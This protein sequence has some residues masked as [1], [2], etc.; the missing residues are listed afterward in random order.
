MNI[1]RREKAKLVSASG[2]GKG[3]SK[4]RNVRP[5]G[6]ADL[7]SQIKTLTISK[8]N[9]L[10]ILSLR[11]LRMLKIR[12]L[13]NHTGRQKRLSIK[14]FFMGFYRKNKTS[15]ASKGLGLTRYAR[16]RLYVELPP[17]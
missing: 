12:S 13:E 8:M 7:F 5:R 15:I 17:P 2:S 4:Y 14:N 16:T 9:E 1:H 3:S 10:K 11:S 6:V